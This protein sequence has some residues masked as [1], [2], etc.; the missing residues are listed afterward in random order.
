M[1]H[2]YQ[3]FDIHAHVHGPEFEDDI[4]GVLSRAKEAGIGI[5]TVGTD[6][7]SSARAV[8]L[9]E[10]HGGVWATV[11]VH[12]TDT[13][14]ENI[15]KELL[16]GLAKRD[17]TVS[18][19]EC[20]LDYFRMK[21]DEAAEKARQKKIFEEQIEI[22]LETNLPLM[23]HCREAHEDVL[24]I[25][26]SKKREHGGKLRGDIHFFS[27]GIDT[28][29]RYLELDFSLSFTGV[30]TFTH[31]YDEAVAYVPLDMIM[32]ETDCPYVAPV[33]Y[34]GKRNEPSYVVE[35][36]KRI[37]EIRQKPLPLV[38]ETLVENARRTFFDA[39]LTA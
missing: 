33:P 28:A 1:T 2:N 15:N 9:A 32:S 20:G 21:G 29:K 3:Y 16:T 26:Q 36:V 38:A 39:N 34:R 37:A 13:K 6:E 10:A 8:S 35:V 17:R 27:G 18:I 25:L 14:T 19:G 22:A 30:I 24:S 12:P 31:D 7:E 5:I 11:G 23:I 4:A